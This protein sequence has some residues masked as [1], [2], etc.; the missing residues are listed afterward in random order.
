M[1]EILN[2]IGEKIRLYRK[3]QRL[4]LDDLAK[5]ICKSKATV[6]KYEKGEISI[7]IS[8]LYDIASALEVNIEQLL[9]EKPVHNNEYSGS[10]IPHFFRDLTHFYGY[11]YDGRSN[12]VLRMRFDVSHSD[13]ENQQ[14]LMGYLNF[15]DYE[16]YPICENTYYGTIEHFDALSNVQLI[17]KHFPL[18][19]VSIQI[20]A[21]SLD[22]TYKWG[23]WQGLSTRPLMPMATKMIIC[24][25]R[26]KEDEELINMLKISKEDI[27][28]LKH[29]NML[30]V[31]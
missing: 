13:V 18:E 17:N 28:L 6:S 10:K 15:S 4:T 11:W 31:L 29:Y 7:D 26:M 12:S 14:K 9:Y 30:T 23:L 5:I 25:E 27:R 24:R 19:K 16:H 8:T 3:K 1:Q 22:F 20:L 2:E 21:T